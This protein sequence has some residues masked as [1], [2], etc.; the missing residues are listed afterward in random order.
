MFLLDTRYPNS[1]LTIP[2]ANKNSGANSE[3]KCQPIIKNVFDVRSYNAKF[4]FLIQPG[5]YPRDLV[6]KWAINEYTICK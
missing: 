1:A 6:P 2:V 4:Q 5:V 3:T